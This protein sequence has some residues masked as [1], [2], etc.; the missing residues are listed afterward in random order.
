MRDLNSQVARVL[1]H[2]L[3]RCE[4]LFNRE[5]Y[6]AFELESGDVVGHLAYLAANPT[7]AGLV[8]DP[9]DWPGQLSLP[10]D[11]N[12]PPQRVYQPEAGFYGR[13]QSK[14]YPAHVDLELT[15]PPGFESQDS[16][17]N[18]FRFQLKAHLDVAR[19]KR[20]PGHVW[21]PT[22]S[23]P[24]VDP[25][26]A[27]PG[28]RRPTFKVRP[29]LAKSA[30]VERKQDL[31]SWREAY[32]HALYAWQAGAREVVFPAGTFLMGRLHRARVAPLH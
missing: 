6:V 7:A 28:S 9:D 19:R 5:G 20:G 15:L 22:H 8:K 4:N 21:P 25:F 23:L 17:L 32:R 18:A 1:N 24:R 13:G 30:S 2:R 14:T 10:D 12:Q 3:D 31:K 11:F 29:H 26:S 16:F 27:P